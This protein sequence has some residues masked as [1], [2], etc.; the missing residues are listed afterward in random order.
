M[1][2]AAECAE[3][4]KPLPPA[5]ESGRPRRFC[6]DTCRS[7]ARRARER[8]RKAEAQEQARRCSTGLAGHSCPREAEFELAVH[9][10][11]FR[12]CGRCHEVTLLFLINQGVPATAVEV[13]RLTGPDPASAEA[14]Q[15]P[16]PSSARIL[17]IED[18]ERVSEAL[19]HRLD[20]RG[21]RVTT[22]RTGLDG[23][24]AAYG[25]RPDLVLLDLG[26]PDMDGFRL[27]RQLRGVSDVPVIV[28][29]ARNGINDRIVGLTS[30]A[31]DYLVKPFAVGE[32]LA[33]I[34]RLLQR[35]SARQWAA[36]V[37]D[38]GLLRLDS[39]RRE[40]HVDG[41]QLPL[42]PIEFRLLELL[43]RNAGAVQPLDKLVGH[44]WED[45]G[46]PGATTRVKF[47]VSRLRSK[48]DTTALGSACIVS[49]RGVG[50]LYRPQARTRTSAEIRP[51]AGYG[52]AAGLL[53]QLDD[54]D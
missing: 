8:L 54:A 48:L 43:T 9:E 37:Y 33:R 35:E 22:E 45:P 29:T 11:R 3:C 18:D 14:P 44:A 5:P 40:V 36:E 25:R 32:L 1:T 41:V 47:A 19:R 6:S 21:F 50:Y 27:L 24:R 20:S 34:T 30:G 49:A 53:R 15:T 28:V 13:T 39:L 26:L 7:A 38:D 10:R 42:T 16:A 23:L 4:A 17:L 12:V 51:S 52:H 2:E 46:G 31:D